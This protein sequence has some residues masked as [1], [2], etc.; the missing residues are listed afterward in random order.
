MACVTISSSWRQHYFWRHV[1]RICDW[2]RNVE[3]VFLDPSNWG[4]GCSPQPRSHAT[5]ANR[6]GTPLTSL[7]LSASLMCWAMKRTPCSADSTSGDSWRGKV[8]SE[9]VTATGQA[10]KSWVNHE[11]VV[12]LQTNSV[13]LSPQANYTDWAT[14]ICQRN[15]VPTFVERGCRVVSAA[16]PI[17]SLISVF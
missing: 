8:L 17:R 12:G 11:Q 16:D 6:Q 10:G 15:L 13:A 1:F 3:P 9:S 4:E 5:A 2:N 14:A 7:S